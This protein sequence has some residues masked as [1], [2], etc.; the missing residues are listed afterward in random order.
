MRRLSLDKKEWP[1]RV[2]FYLGVP[3]LLS[4]PLG[5]FQA[6]YGQYFTPLFSFLFWVPIWIGIWF[7]AEFALRILH[8]I[9]RPWNTPAF[10]E[11][12]VAYALVVVLTAFVVPPYMEYFS[13]FGSGIPAD[14]FNERVGPGGPDYIFN[15]VRSG[16]PGLVAWTLLRTLYAMLPDK[17]DSESSS[18]NGLSKVEQAYLNPEL[19]GH[20]EFAYSPFRKTLA[21]EGIQNLSQIAALQ[22]SD[23]YVDVHLADGGHHM[24]LSR[25][26]DAIESMANE[27]G[28]RV[29]RSF[30][31]RRDAIA[32][33]ESGG[34]TLIVHLQNGMQ[35]PVSTKYRG[36]LE[37]FVGQS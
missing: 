36:L 6:G 10:V 33:L 27:D 22:A 17:G 29:H 25:F 15:L 7:A 24:I 11:I 34:S 13:R 2:A 28:L 14:F 3:L 31:V 26:S 23:H 37:H 21:N 20:H 8:A 18:A 16:L 1:Y 12:V 30:W 32:K 35:C 19:Q 5:L 4:L 9:L